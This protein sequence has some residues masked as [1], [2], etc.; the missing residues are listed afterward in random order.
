MLIWSS[1]GHALPPPTFPARSGHNRRK[2]L[3]TAVFQVAVRGTY[4]QQGHV[5]TGVE[6]DGANREFS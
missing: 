1:T 5:S 2:E 6:T 4:G 3:H